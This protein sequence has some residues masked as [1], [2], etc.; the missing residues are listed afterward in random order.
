MSKSSW[1]TDSYLSTSGLTNDFDNFC[2]IRHYLS[3]PSFYCRQQLTIMLLSLTKGEIFKVMKKLCI[4]LFTVLILVGCSSQTNKPTNPSGN[5]GN[6]SNEVKEDEYV[7][8]KKTGT[9]V[10]CFIDL[11]AEKG[12]EAEPVGKSMANFPYAGNEDVANY[13]A[14]GCQATDFMAFGKRTE[15]GVDFS[16]SLDSVHTDMYIYDGS[17]EIIEYT[18]KQHK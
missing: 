6:E 16:D 13:I 17:Q 9:R 11:A 18:V 12:I 14:S 5:N 7:E 15:K 2:S 4:I 1:L 10:A 8:T 3:P